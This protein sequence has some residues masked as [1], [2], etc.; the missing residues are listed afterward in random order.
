MGQLAPA[1]DGDE[2]AGKAS[3]VHVAPEV[4]VEAGEA[5]GPETDVGGL[6]LDLQ[7][8]HETG[9]AAAT[10]RATS[11]QRPTDAGLRVIASA[12]VYRTRRLATPP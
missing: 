2:P 8:C 10:A 6:D 3:F 7:R 11:P 5:F 12:A 9:L 1:G 4:R